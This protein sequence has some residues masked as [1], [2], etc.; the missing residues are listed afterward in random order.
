MNSAVPF[1]ADWQ[2]AAVPAGAATD[3]QALAALPADTLRWW[4]A[5]V[6]GTA[7]AA[8]FDAGQADLDRL[9]PLD[10]QDVWYRTRFDTT[11]EDAGAELV[12]EGLATLAE[13][14]LDGA[15]I[16]RSDNMFLAH[17]VD[18]PDGLPP[19]THTLEIRFASV[20]KA[21]AARRPRPR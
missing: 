5:A 9:P 2:M 18:L 8:L 20:P 7:M 10:G 6:P 12:F 11:A 17:R 16:L 15:S 14:W 19:G 4:P 1:S 21:L 3:P 13:C